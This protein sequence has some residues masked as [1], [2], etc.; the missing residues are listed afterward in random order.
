MGESRSMY[1]M[2]DIPFYHVCLCFR[3]RE[4]FLAGNIAWIWDILLINFWLDGSDECVITNIAV[5]ALSH[6][7][8]LFLIPVNILLD[9]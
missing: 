9:T 5:S 4:Q 3:Y 7:L 2:S 8:S 1:I 6:V